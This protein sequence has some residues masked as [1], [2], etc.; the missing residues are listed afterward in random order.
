MTTPGEAEWE[1]AVPFYLDSRMY[2]IKY[3]EPQL[4]RI[5]NQFWAHVQE[6]EGGHGDSHGG[7]HALTKA[8][9]S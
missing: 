8:N 4:T 3:P 2:D 5:L 9:A 1:T 6:R 7:Q